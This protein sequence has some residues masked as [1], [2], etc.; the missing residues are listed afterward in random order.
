MVPQCNLVAAQ[1]PCKRIKI[2]TAHS[3][4]QITGGFLH[5]IYRIKNVTFKN[6]NRNLECSGIVLNHLTVFLIIARIHHQILYLKIHLAV[7]LQ[8][9][10]QLRHQ[11][12]IL[13]AGHT[14]RHP[15]SIL[16]QLIIL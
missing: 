9:L 13:T 16:N 15:V 11:H 14:D 8:F 10:K 1:L 7:F 3:C 5:G 6:R 12:G 4:T 2:S